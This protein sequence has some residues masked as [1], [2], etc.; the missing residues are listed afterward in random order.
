VNDFLEKITAIVSAKLDVENLPI[1]AQ[2]D[3]KDILNSLI[4][5]LNDCKEDLAETH[6]MNN[7]RV[8]VHVQMETAQN[9]I[10]DFKESL[11]TSNTGG[12]GTGSLT[13]YIFIIPL[14]IIM[15]SFAMYIS[16]RG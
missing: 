11:S 7:F 9:R 14:N 3:G 12:M 4:N 15:G 13:F 5:D 6:Q 1:Y 10:W 8:C 2:E 16:R